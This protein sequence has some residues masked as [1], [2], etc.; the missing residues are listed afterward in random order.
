[1]SAWLLRV[2][3]VFARCHRM[4][5]LSVA[6]N[7]GRWARINAAVSPG[8]V[9]SSALFS[10]ACRSIVAR[11]GAEALVYIA[12]VFHG[13]Q[14]GIDVCSHRNRGRVGCG[15]GQCGDAVGKGYHPQAHVHAF[16]AADYCPAA[17]GDCAS[18]FHECDIAPHVAHCQ[19]QKKGVRGKAG[20]DV[21]RVGTGGQRGEVQG[22]CMS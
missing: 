13:R 5:P 2:D 22:A 15:M 19:N 6:V 3:A 20:D 18:N 4:C 7:Q 12:C 21:C 16:T 14:H 9:L 1:M 8:M 10:R 11:G 17:V